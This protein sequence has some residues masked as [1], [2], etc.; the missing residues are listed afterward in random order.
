MIMQRMPDPQNPGMRRRQVL[1]LAC[2]LGLAAC[3]GGQTSADQRNRHGG[4]NGN[5]TFPATDYYEQAR[6]RPGGTLHI[7]TSSDTATL[8]F[9]AISH[10]N[11][12]WLG[13]ILFDN[14]VY[15]NDKGEITPWLARSWK[16]S[17]DGKTYI[18]HL[19]PDV[20]F[21]DGTPFNAEAV[22]INFEHMR[23]PRTKSQLAAAY[24]AP[25][26]DG[27]VIDRY[28]F[29]AHLREP[30]GPFLYVLAQSWLSMV[31]PKQIEERPE[32]I[33][34][35]PIGSGPFTLESYVRQQGLHFVRRPDYHWAPNYVRHRGPAYLDRIDVDIVPE[36]LARYAGLASGQYQLL[37]EAPLQNAAAIRA[38]PR[39]VF[40][41]RI[42]TGL[43]F[44]ALTFNFDRDPFRDVRVRRALAIAVDR[45]GIANSIGFGE[46]VP[47]TDFLASTTRYYDPRWRNV[48]AYNPAEA[49]RLLDEAGW[50]ARDAQGFRVRGGQRLGAEMLAQDSSLT[51]AINAAVQGELKKVGFDLHIVLMPPQQ[52]ATRR[53]AG[54]YQALGAGVWH[55]NT[56]DALY[57]IHHSSEI[58]SAKRIGQNTAH[59]RDAVLDD[60]LLRARHSTDPKELQA[61]Y[62]QAQKRLVDIVPGIPL[63]ENNTVV[64]YNREL[65]GLLFDTSHNTPYLT[66]AWIGEPK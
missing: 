8:D 27:R 3:S 35:H 24:I 38:D 42:R 4:P 59:V 23:D 41:S 37:T 40:D 66:A 65:R 18:F 6:G 13:R 34:S 5:Y 61:L 16:I 47:K 53:N 9:H 31:S 54:D 11:V 58:T 30:Y 1:A 32:Q 25:Y 56:P 36:P 15:L 62:S 22:R 26:A 63:D 43:P 45:V 28:T 46:F 10:G 48:L 14:L 7:A 17:P 44:R 55:S 52:L 2:A 49:N 57:I 12:Q 60:L 29:E 50:K 51:N 21:S 20:T 19:R 64:A 39:L 33:A